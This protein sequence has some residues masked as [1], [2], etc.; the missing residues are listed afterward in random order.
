MAPTASE[1]IEVSRRLNDAIWILTQT[2]VDTFVSNYTTTIASH[3][4]RLESFNRMVSHELRQP[5]GTLVYALPL[6]K[7]EAERGDLRD[8]STSWK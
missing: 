5:L 2:T 6:L 3:A 8:T 4:E 7:I 1:A